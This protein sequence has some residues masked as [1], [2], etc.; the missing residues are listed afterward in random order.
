[1]GDGS[2]NPIPPACFGSPPASVKAPWGWS[3]PVAYLGD[4]VADVPDG[5]ERR[6]QQPEPALAELAVVPPH[7]QA[8][9]WEAAQRL[10]TAARLPGRSDC[11]PPP[12]H[13]SRQPALNVGLAAG[14]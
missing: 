13:F 6:K 7:L 1:M 5:A 8:P 12:P 9:V 3:P 10:Q 4:T 11:S 14:S 2:T